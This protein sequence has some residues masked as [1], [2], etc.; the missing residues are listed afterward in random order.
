MRGRSFALRLAVIT[1]LLAVAAFAFQ[2]TLVDYLTPFLMLP[3]LAILLLALAAATLLGAWHAFRAGGSWGYRLAPVA[4]CVVA[5]LVLLVTPF[6]R[7][8]LAVDFRVKRH[9]REAAIPAI[10]GRQDKGL[11]SLNEMGWRLSAGGNEAVV[12]DCGPVR[13]VLFYTY[14]GILDNYSG[15]LFVP[16]GGEPARF[17]DLSDAGTTEIL[18]WAGSWFFVSHT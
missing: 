2:W 6:T 15:F 4:V 17:E 5:A 12:D 8:A 13:C 1:S 16:P 18:P 11:A 9:A 14:R 7:V 3:L 10:L